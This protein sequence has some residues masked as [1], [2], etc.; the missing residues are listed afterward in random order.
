MVATARKTNTPM[1][2]ETGN[3]FT[4]QDKTPK[5]LKITNA[6]DRESITG[7]IQTITIDETHKQNTIE[8]VIDLAVYGRDFS[9]LASKLGKYQSPYFTPI[10]ANE[11]FSPQPNFGSR[12]PILTLK[13]LSTLL[14][15]S[16]LRKSYGQLADTART[17][18]LVNLFINV[19]RIFNAI[20][21]KESWHQR[22]WLANPSPRLKH[23]AD[24]LEKGSSF[25]KDLA[26]K[27]RAEINQLSEEE[28]LALHKI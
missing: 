17:E 6:E 14:K 18:A 16:E 15:S 9:K 26:V 13:A 12:D 4:L 10:S 8:S 3:K 28:Q 27:C 11:F 24:A 19:R 21:V 20:T 7:I 2:S 22:G 1:T 23:I 25:Y 5:T